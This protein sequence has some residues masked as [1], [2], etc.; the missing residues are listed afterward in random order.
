MKVGD[1]VELSLYG[2]RLKRLI[3]VE[4]EDVGVVVSLLKGWHPSHPPSYKVL[5][6]KSRPNHSSWMYGHSER[7]ERRDLKKVRKKKL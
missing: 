6:A 7:F 5:W 3:W 1:L 2:S 4:Q